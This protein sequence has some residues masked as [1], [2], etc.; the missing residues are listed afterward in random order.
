M[1]PELQW[2][3]VQS[4]M[5][6][7]IAVLLEAEWKLPNPGVW[8]PPD[9]GDAVDVEAN[10]FDIEVVAKQAKVQLRKA[11]WKTVGWVPDGRVGR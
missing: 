2:M 4:A 9:G 1:H 11:A 3:Q 7:A 6:A 8:I 10:E 5:S